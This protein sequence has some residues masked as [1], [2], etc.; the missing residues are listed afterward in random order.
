MQVLS[1]NGY[2]HTLRT[3]IRAYTH[4]DIYT[5]G[6]ALCPGTP[7][8]T[9]PVHTGPGHEDHVSVKCDT[10]ELKATHR[11]SP[12]CA[13]SVSGALLSG[14]RDLVGAFG[15]RPFGRNR[16]LTAWRLPAPLSRRWPSEGAMTDRPSRTSS[17]RAAICRLIVPESRCLVIRSAGLA[18][19]GILDKP[20]SLL[21]TRSCIQR[22]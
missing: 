12:D 18:L 6:N 17:P 7:P 14:S 8:W 15:A 9:G 13:H 16:A 19:P 2:G 3:T 20:K 10:R 5:S 22:Y 1:Q 4:E 21:F 11:N